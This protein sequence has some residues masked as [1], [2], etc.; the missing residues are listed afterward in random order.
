[1]VWLVIGIVWLTLSVLAVVWWMRLVT[2][3]CPALLDDDG[4]TPE[5]SLDAARSVSA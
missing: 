5:P 2:C 1:M 4:V 3:T